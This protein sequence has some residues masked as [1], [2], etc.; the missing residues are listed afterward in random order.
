MDTGR[1]V[2]GLV[3]LAVSAALVWFAVDRVLNDPDGYLELDPTGRQLLVVNRSGIPGAVA[4]PGK[5]SVTKLILPL[6]E[7]Q[8]LIS[9][10]SKTTIQ[11]VQRGTGE[12]LHRETRVR[13]RLIAMPSGIELFISRTTEKRDAVAEAISAAGGITTTAV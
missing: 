1:F 9:G 10:T 11:Y 12:D 4:A 5:R 8:G 6:S 7:I 3:A 2:F 13:H